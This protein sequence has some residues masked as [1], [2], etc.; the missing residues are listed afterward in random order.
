MSPFDPHWDAPTPLCDAVSA[1]V[2]V[3]IDPSL[4]G[5]VVRGWASPARATFVERLAGLHNDAPPRKIPLNIADDRL[6]GGLD[7]AAT[8]QAGRPIQRAGILAEAQGSLALLAM[9]ERLSPATAAR[10]AIALDSGG[11]VFIALDEGIGP[12]EAPPTALLDRLA[13]TVHDLPDGAAIW[14]P[15]SV[16][17][18]ARA[19]LGGVSCPPE[20]IAQLCAASVA[21]GVSTMRAEI[22]TCRAARAAAALRGASVVAE[23]D[24]ELAAR[25]ILAPRAT[26]RPEPAPEAP[27]EPQTPPEA[28]PETQAQKLD[29]RLDDAHSVALPDH[30][31]AALAGH[32]GPRRMARGGG[33]AGATHS[34]Q[35]GRPIAARRGPLAGQARLSVLD[36]LRAAAPWQRLRGNP[37]GS[38]RIAVR[39]EDFHIKRFREQPRR[40]AIFTVDASGSSALNRLAEAKGAI[41]RLL[42]DC[43]VQRDEVALIA[44]RGD[45]AQVLLPPTHALARVRRALAALPGGGPTPLSQGIHAALTLALAARRT[46]R[47]PLLV[48]LT[49]GGANIGQN[50]KPGRAT[51]GADALAAAQ[52]CAV[53]DLPSLVVDIAP[54]RQPFVAE[55]AA[56]MR[57][58]YLA[59]P[60][61]DSARLSRAVQAQDYGASHGRAAR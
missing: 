13:F 1:A 25:L 12:D 33:S 21:L 52:A 27:P 11:V 8:L 38:G 56:R 49:D 17:A 24:A 58:R 60:V 7:L 39:A 14:P 10:L 54:R 30:L 34:L 41:L 47:R 15:A 9:A 50:G 35:R 44:F 46:G 19:A 23:A 37:P 29:D 2:L 42:A 22:F 59:L 61:A 57:G 32:A 26:Q 53:A 28:G 45:G 16:V 48:L 3:A 36:T 43:Y 40:L 51:A 20:I 18:R 31:L 5:I 6:L 4:G 55:L